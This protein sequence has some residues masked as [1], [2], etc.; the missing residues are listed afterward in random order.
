MTT[1]DRLD[2]ILRRLAIAL[3][4]L[5]AAAERRLEVEAERSD[6]DEELAVMQDDRA[7]LAIELD[8]ALARARA[9]A[10]ANAE[11]SR[12]LERA[13]ESIRAVLTAGLEEE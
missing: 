11:V 6:R 10:S 8:G 7:R 12:R 3:D 4:H 2:A 9:L 13:S 1:P 5:E